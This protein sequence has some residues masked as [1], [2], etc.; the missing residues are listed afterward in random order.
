[1]LEICIFFAQYV[2]F[3]SSF[4]ALLVHSSLQ[5]EKLVVLHVQVRKKCLCHDKQQISDVAVKEKNKEREKNVSTTRLP[6]SKTPR[7]YNLRPQ[8]SKLKHLVV[9][10]L[11][12]NIR[13]L[14]FFVCV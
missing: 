6:T 4:F 3:S 12:R 8:N 7:G 11:Y 10:E 9:S 13:H 2:L 14:S 5:L 1:M